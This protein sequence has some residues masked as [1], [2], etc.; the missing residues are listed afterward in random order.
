M[1]PFNYFVTAQNNKLITYARFVVELVAQYLFIVNNFFLGCYGHQQLAYSATSNNH[2]NNQVGLRMEK[3][4]MTLQLTFCLKP[5]TLFCIVYFYGFWGCPHPLLKQFV[6]QLT[7]QSAGHNLIITS[8]LI[9]EIKL[10]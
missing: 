1:K 2:Y 8:P 9:L 4:S 3:G 6:I 7:L 5:T 10:N